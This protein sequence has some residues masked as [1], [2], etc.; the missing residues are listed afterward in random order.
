MA[1]HLDAAFS[2]SVDL[3]E[4]PR[5][6]TFSKKNLEN[7][8]FFDYWRVVT[9][10]VSSEEKLLGSEGVSLMSSVKVLL[11]LRDRKVEIE[12][13]VFMKNP[14]NQMNQKAIG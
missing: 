12:V 6:I 9:I 3:V 13:H 5:K 8:Q 14:G 7:S 2:F 1:A 10:N 11:K 4:K